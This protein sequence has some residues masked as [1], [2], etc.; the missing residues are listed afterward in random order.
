MTRESGI[1]QRDCERHIQTRRNRETDSMRH[2]K[3][4]TVSKEVR[5]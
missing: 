4:E 5:K 3:S 2:R 1:R